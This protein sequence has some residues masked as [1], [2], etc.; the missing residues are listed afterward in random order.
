MPLLGAKNGVLESVWSRNMLRI[1]MRKYANNLRR[2]D[3]CS[4]LR[5]FRGKNRS[6]ERVPYVDAA[7]LAG[8]RGVPRQAQMHFTFICVACDVK[9][10]EA[11]RYVPRRV[12]GRLTVA[13]FLL[14]SMC[15]WAEGR[16]SRPSPSH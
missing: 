3:A 10:K 1:S 11:F 12:G 13:I 8:R 9:E 15:G 7:R 14:R 16:R 2:T 5:D 6:E 4:N